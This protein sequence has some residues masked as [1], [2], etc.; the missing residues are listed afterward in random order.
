MVTES[1]A[2]SL[3]SSINKQYKIFSGKKDVDKLIH[4]MIEYIIRDFIDSWFST[5]SESKEFVDENTR[6]AIEEFVV[7]ICKRIKQ[8][9]FVPL[10]TTKLI[11]DLSNHTKLYRLSIQSTKNE[12]LHKLD[13]N[14]KTPYQHN[15]KTSKSIKEH[16]RNKS[17]TDLKWNIG[18]SIIQK[19]IAN[20]TFYS[21][22]TD[23]NNLMDPKKCLIQTFFE[24]S[25]NIFKKECLDDQELEK[26]LVHV[27]ETILYFTISSENF[28]CITLRSLIASLMANIVKQIINMFS[29]PDFI[30]LQIA[31]QVCFLIQYCAVKN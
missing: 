16:R 6:V 8:F 9:D 11:D 3:K 18:N 22:A 4:I 27:M 1:D 31:R 10:A 25:N 26:H 17:D 24:N 23:E 20:S 5:I 29:D 28:S 30:N 13:K 21:V 2:F 15:V 12:N 7:N 19:T 14:N